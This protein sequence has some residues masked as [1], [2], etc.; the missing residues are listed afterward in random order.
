[1][2]NPS[3][4]LESAERL[5]LMVREMRLETDDVMRIRF[6]AR[7]RSPLPAWE[8]GAHID[9]A[10]ANGVERQYSLCGDPADCSEWQIAVLRE[11]VSRGGSRFIH[12]K[13]RPGDLVTVSAPRNNFRLE[14]A[15]KTVFIAGGIGITPLLPMIRQTRA[16]GRDWRLLYLGKTRERMAFIEAV[17]CG[18]AT[19]A[20]SAVGGRMDIF[21][22]I[23]QVDTG[24]RIYAC[25]PQAMLDA[26]EERSA[27]WPKGALR[28]ERFQARS[29]VDLSDSKEFEVVAQRSGL[30][31]IVSPGCSILQMLEEAG[32]PVPSSCLEGVCGTCETAII[33]GEA[34]HRDSILSPDERETNE[35]MMICVSRSRTPRL[36]LDI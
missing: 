8:P 7:D 22:W 10:F 3:R 14:P 1:M 9:I 25:G 13:L 30:S 4:A 36:V 5:R 12:D 21:D 32:L 33:D 16:E 24:T 15:E 34:E 17:E 26:L 18:A 29:F 35:T 11:P 6:S 19:I 2:P 31:V 28:I 23:G 20:C 27:A